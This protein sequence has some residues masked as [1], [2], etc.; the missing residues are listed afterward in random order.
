MISPKNK[1]IDT[2]N[3][4]RIKIRENYDELELWMNSGAMDKEQI[5]GLKAYL[6]E[7]MQITDER[8]FNVIPFSSKK[9]SGSS[10]LNPS[11]YLLE[12]INK[13]HSPITWGAQWC[14]Q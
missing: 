14:S 5:D 1:Y 8:A 13:H 7:N 11:I 12:N 10:L 4:I 3:G 6:K 9:W 2:M